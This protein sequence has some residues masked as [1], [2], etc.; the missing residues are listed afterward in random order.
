MR[1]VSTIAPAGTFDDAT[2]IDRVTLD[3]DDRQR[4]RIVLTAEQG[5]RVLLDFDRP[6]TLRDGDGL[7]LNDGTIVLVSGMPEPLA[8]IVAPSPRDFVRIAWHLGNRHTDVQIAGQRIRIRR[9]HVLEEMLR[10]LGATV[11][12]I[13]APFD[14]Q[15]TIPHSHDHPHGHEHHHHGHAHGH[16][17]SHHGHGHH[18]HGHDHER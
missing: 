1:R 8:E 12:A 16:G 10:G 18:R 2:A 3:A 17:H 4:R 14:P 5:T 9:D 11:T 15:A 7:V 13:E 6:V